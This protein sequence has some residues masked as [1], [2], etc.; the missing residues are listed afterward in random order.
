MLVTIYSAYVSPSDKVANDLITPMQVGAAR[1]TVDLDM[2]RDDDGENISLENP[3]FNELTALYWMWKN[4]TR[5]DYLG[6]S[7][8]RRYFDFSR[9]AEHVVDPYGQIAEVR[10]SNGF[11]DE[12]GLNQATAQKILSGYDAVLPLP[13]D[14]RNLGERSVESHYMH[15]PHH[16]GE[17]LRHAD[18]IIAD[19]YPGDHRHWRAVM[20]GNS[21]YP[22]NL[23]VFERALFEE[24]CCWLFPL[25]FQINAAIDISRLPPPGRR[26]VGFIAER[27]MGVFVAR[28]IERRGP[29][30][31]ILELPRLYIR[32]A[33]PSPARRLGG[34]VWRALPF[35]LRAAARPLAMQVSRLVR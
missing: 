21:F 1:A 8:Y 24:Y 5:S 31:R 6:L 10:W 18:R 23:L 19:I 2:Q 28:T 22:T 25:L 32:G 33:L 27:L 11:F 30:L 3:A 20:G 26:A 15:A 13:L 17:H 9:N 16:Y 34:S 7:H 29:R 12:Y 35:P 4:D 14:V